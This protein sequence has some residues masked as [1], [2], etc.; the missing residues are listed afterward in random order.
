MPVE[1]RLSEIGLADLLDVLAAAECTGALELFR[2]D[3]WGQIALHQGAV[4]R[5]RLNASETLGEALVRAGK[6]TQEQLDDALAIQ[7]QEPHRKL[8]LGTILVNSGAVSKAQLERFLRERIRLAVRELC[9]WDTGTFRWRPQPGSADAGEFPDRVEVAELLAD[10]AHATVDERKLARELPETDT[11][12]RPAPRLGEREGPLRLSR[13]EWAVF[14]LVGRGRRVGD[15][16]AHAVHL[17]RHA[18]LA[19]LRSLLASGVLVSEERDARR[20][21]LIENG[22]RELVRA[23]RA[24]Y[25]VLV[26]PHGQ[27]L[28]EHG[29]RVE[30]NGGSIAPLAAG[31]LMCIEAMGTG[32]HRN[33]GCVVL[34]GGEILVYLASVTG[35]AILVV[36]CDGKGQLGHV[37]LLAR[38]FAE[39]YARFIEAVLQPVALPPRSQ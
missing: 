10:V 33:G 9:N 2:A 21:R 36:I 30:T 13:D 34:E 22:I 17:D 35:S 1:G 38:D 15:V 14:W 12:V 39:A 7:S 3:E 25:C 11:V 23:S 28:Y 31:A 6:I 8:L 18:A 20:F 24:R 16:V 5:A 29:M 37:R 32:D 27:A 26:S 4:I 19:A